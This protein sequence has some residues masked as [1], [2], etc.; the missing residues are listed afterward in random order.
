MDASADRCRA[1][2]DPDPR[3]VLGPVGNAG[4]RLPFKHKG[5][6]VMPPCTPVAAYYGGHYGKLKDSWSKR[7]PE[8]RAQDIAA[9][10]SRRGV[11]PLD[12]KLCVGCVCADTSLNV[13]MRER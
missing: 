11:F 13:H 7:Q 3:W 9:A 8:S 5:V 4:L 12:S 10:R 1:Y 6:A 2:E